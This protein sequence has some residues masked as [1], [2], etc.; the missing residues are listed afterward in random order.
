MSEVSCRHAPAYHTFEPRIRLEV[1]C[2]LVWFDRLTTNGQ[3]AW[4]SPRTGALPPFALSLSKGPRTGRPPYARSV[5]FDRLTTNGRRDIRF[6]TNGRGTRS[7]MGRGAQGVLEREGGWGRR[8]G[9]NP[10]RTCLASALASLGGALEVRSVCRGVTDIRR[11][12][13]AQTSNPFSNT[14]SGLSRAIQ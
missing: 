6:I 5:W 4:I 12:R 8:Y 10:R 2:P 1:V 14:H 3:G 9:W 11:R 7:G 13:T